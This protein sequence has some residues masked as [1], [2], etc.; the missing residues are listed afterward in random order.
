MPEATQ[1]TAV[2]ASALNPKLEASWKARLADEFKQ[3]YFHAL[4]TFLTEEKNS[5]QV[6]YPPGNRIFN[7]FNTTPFDAVKVVILGQDPYHGPD[8]AHGLSFSV[9]PGIKPPPSLMNMFKELRDDVGFTIPTHGCLE[10]WAQQGVLLLNSAL[11]VRAGQPQSHA[12]KGWERFTDAAVKALNEGRQG[13]VFLLWGRPAQLKGNLVDPARHHVLKSVHPS[14]LSAFGGF[15]GC[16][17]FS[18]ANA[19]LA[20]S[21]QAPIDWQ[22]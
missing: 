15:F 4:K 6:V 17:H 1:E 16:K 18:K 13:L 10:K 22:I 7:A 21:G 5:G 19:L 12:G 14:P 9:L 20:K 11:T 2:P 8:Q 3:P